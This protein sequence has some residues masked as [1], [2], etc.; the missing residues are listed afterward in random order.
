MSADKLSRREAK[1]KRQWEEVEEYRDLLEAPDKFD[2]GFTLRTVIGVLFISL[3]MTPGEMFFGLF[4]RECRLHL[5]LHNRLNN[6]I[7]RH[8]EAAF[9]TQ[10][11]NVVHFR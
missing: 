11:Y 1:K 9:S 5:K 7:K 4:T 10:Q 8:S 3:I 6:M 2:E